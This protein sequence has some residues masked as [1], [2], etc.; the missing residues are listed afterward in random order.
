MQEVEEYKKVGEKS[1]G[2]SFQQQ[3]ENSE[4]KEEFCQSLKSMQ[5]KH[6]EKKTITK[7]SIKRNM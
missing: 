3:D 7:V 1:S 4:Q 2:P 6:Q 5:L